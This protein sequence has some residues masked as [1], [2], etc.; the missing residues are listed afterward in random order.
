MNVH[1]FLSTSEFGVEIILNFFAYL[2]NGPIP[3]SF[4]G[5]FRS[6]QTKKITA[7]IC[8]KCP[9]SKWCGDLNP[10]PL[11]H[12]SPPVT[13]R[14]GLPPFKLYCLWGD[15]TWR[16]ECW[17]KYE[18]CITYEKMKHGDVNIF[19]VPI[20]ILLQRLVPRL[21]LGLTKHWDDAGFGLVTSC[22]YGRPY[23]GVINIE[24]NALRLDVA[25]HMTIFNQSECVA[26]IKFV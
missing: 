26:M 2:K 17:S 23:A 6:F 18:L 7:N 4:I 14:P 3:A 8:E 20:M 25:S 21:R 22:Y 11:E 12:E 9:S 13:T 10:Q 15:L 16:E 19:N 1:P 24:I 5:Y